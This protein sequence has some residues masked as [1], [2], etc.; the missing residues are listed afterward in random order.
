MSSSYARF[1]TDEKF[2]KEGVCFEEQT[3]RYWLARTGGANTKFKQIFEKLS[4]PFQRQID[5]GTLSEKKSDDMLHKAYARAVVKRWEVKVNDAGEI[6]E[7]GEWREG[8]ETVDGEVLLGP[9]QEEPLIE[10]F[11]RVP[12]F[13]RDLMN[14]STN[15]QYYL[16][17]QAEEQAKN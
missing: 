15:L 8:F 7:D 16:Q 6:D 11:V 4:R 2:E 17:G 9:L 14:D 10:L 12:Q 13:F 1:T 5:T 3:F